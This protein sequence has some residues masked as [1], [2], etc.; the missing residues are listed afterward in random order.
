MEGAHWTEDSEK[1]RPYWNTEEVKQREFERYTN[2][3]GPR[4]LSIFRKSDFSENEGLFDLLPGTLGV[5]QFTTMVRVPVQWEDDVIMQ[6][7]YQLHVGFYED[8]VSVLRPTDFAPHPFT[9]ERPD[10]SRAM[11]LLE[12]TAKAREAIQASKR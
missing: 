9:F 2:T 11:V 12:S 1:T 10:L 8:K 3:L 6:E 5:E 7:G 4:L